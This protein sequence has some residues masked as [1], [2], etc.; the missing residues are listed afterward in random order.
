MTALILCDNC[1][2]P[3][4]GKVEVGP[5]I[6]T[7]RDPSRKTLTLCTVCREALLSGGLAEFGRRYVS[8][9]TIG[10]RD[11]SEC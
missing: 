4:A 8:E 3:N 5:D 11:P 6:G 7:Q 2:M 9:R 1:L 10:R